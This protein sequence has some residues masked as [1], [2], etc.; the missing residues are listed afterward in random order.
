MKLSPRRLITVVLATGA[1]FGLATSGVLAASGAPAAPAQAVVTLSPSSPELAA[2]LPHAS[3]RVTVGLTT[4]INGADS[5]NLVARALA[6]NRA[7]TIFLLHTAQSPFGAAEYIG[8]VFTDDHG[9]GQVRLRL[10]VEEAFASTLV[11]NERVLKELDQI[12]MW[13]ADPADDD[14]CLGP[15]SPIT[16]FDGDKEAGV[17]V[18]NSHGSRPLP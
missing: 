3:A 9:N 4:D 10:I 14:F 2:C 16:P 1:A 8:D 7:Y 5:F 15:D 6:P 11:N 17:Q 18:L 13:F 12:G